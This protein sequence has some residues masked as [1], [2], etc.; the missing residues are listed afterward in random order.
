MSKDTIH[1]FNNLN[2]KG[3]IANGEIGTVGQILHSNGSVAYWALDDN[4]GG[5]ITSVATAN[6]LSGGPITTTGTIGVVTGS[7]L[8]VN[9]TGIHVNSALSITDLALTGNLTVSGT[10]TYINTTTLEVG[11]NIVT[12]NADLGANPPTENAG[13]EIMRGTSAN[14]QFI[15][16]ETNDRW[17]TNG[18]PISISSLVAAGAASGITTLAAGNTTITGFANVSTTLQV[19]TNTSTFGTAAYI[20]A[21]GNVG[22]GTS[23]PAYRLHVVAADGVTGSFFAGASYALRVQ[24]IAATG[25][26]VDAVNNTE[27]T[28]QPLLIGGSLTRFMVSG[29]EKMRLDASG[30]VGIGTSS[31]ST[32]LEVS[33][34]S[35]GATIEVLRLSNPGAGA[36]TAAQIKFTAA[37]TNYGTISGGYGA[38]VPQMTFNL[39][40][41]GNYVWQGTSAE[42]MRLDS[43]GNLGINVEPVAGYGKSIQL[44]QSFGAT[45]TFLFQAVDTDL[46]NLELL[47]NA[48]PP[49]G[50]YTAGYN[51]THTG[52]SA[53]KYASTGGNHIW[54]SASSGTAGSAIT[55]GERMRITLT[56]NVGIGN[57][58]PNSKLV[59]AGTVAMGNTTI[60]GFANVTST[61]QGGAGLTIA[62]AL[63]G[64]TTAA[65][66][67]TTI[68]GFANVTSTIQ[69]GA[70]LT[71]AGALAGVT[72]AAMGNTTITGFANV[73]TS[74]NSAML[75][76]GTSF[77][78][79][80]SQL[81]IS[82]GGS[83]VSLSN[84]TSNRITW[85]T[86]GVAAPTLTSYSAGTKLVLY[87]SVSAGSTGYAIGIDNST[88]WFSTNLITDA[89]GFK[90]YGGTTNYMSANATI[91]SHTGSI[92][93]PIFKD[94]DNTA[95]FFDGAST[96][97]INTLSGNGKTALETADG[98]LRI[99][100]SASFTNGIWTGSSNFLNSSG[101]FGWG[102]NGGTT[103]SRVYIN[104]GTYNGTNVI[105]LDGSNGRITA[106]DVRAPIFYDSDDTTYYI[107]PNGN[108]TRAAYLNGNLWIN[109]KSEPYGEGITFNMPTQATWG[110]LRWYR[111]GPGGS[112]AG[113][114]AF[115][116]FG[117]ESTN[118]IGFHNGTNGWRL[119][120]SFNNS[121]T[122]S[123]R[124]PIFYDSNNTA[125]YIDAAGTT[126][127]GDVQMGNVLNLNGWQESIAT[128]LFRGIEFHSVGDRSYY[129]GKP[130]GAWTQPLE[131]HFF[132]GIRYRAHLSYGGHQFYDI[133]DG[134]LKF[135]ISNGS[136]IVSSAVAFH[137]PI[138][139]DSNDTTYY[140]DAASTSNLNGLT[141]A[142]TITGSITGNA[143]TATSATSANYVG[144]TRD[145]PSSSLQYWQA[146]GLGSTEAPNGDWHNTIRMGHGSPL[147][148]YSSTL[149]IRMTGAGLG[150][151]YTQN[152]TAG[153]PQGWKKH[154]ND[155][156]D[157]SGSGLD[158][159]LLDGKHASDAVGVN[160]VVTR[161]ASNYTYLSYINSSTG[162]NENP[163]ISQIITTNNSDAFYRKS[164]LAH[165]AT[166]LGP[167][168]IT[169]TGTQYFQSNRDTT[170]NS[171]P[172]QAYSTSGGAIMSFHRAGIYAINMGLD[173]DNIF[174]IAG[175]SAAANAFQMDGSGNL[176]MLG[177]VTAYS[178]IRK[179][180]DIT[181]IE[182]ALDMVSRMRGVRFRRIDTDQVGVGVIA[183]E[184]LEVLPE[185][186]QQGIGNDDTMSVAYGNI[187]G[188]LIEAIKEQQAHI[189][190]LETKINSF[191]QRLI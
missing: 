185:V 102:S 191:E 163:T 70:G 189:N 135:S 151:I 25:T 22:I 72:T 23:S 136:N 51:Y 121:V 161:D 158:A 178:D 167:N 141:V 33:S 106:L 101:I 143:G 90:W 40:A 112:Y 84:G 172:L 50:G 75:T 7:T 155:G 10:R 78:A 182:N 127:L 71:I 27:A 177:N 64:V 94:S 61:I 134:A 55:F 16:D 85:G 38:T 53:T 120:H 144:T 190:K 66:G 188:V 79:N 35:A 87:D 166:S 128:T 100:Q 98:Y 109:P 126:R 80:S 147:S 59:V 165:L 176:T 58:A 131:I 8:T 186:V 6:G 63:A 92:H 108:G 82:S 76:V 9:T 159:D 104:G 175:W 118:D 24:S 111:N 95:F 30:N 52:S 116:Y 65:M 12:L 74:V 140:I 105:A 146:S 107:D 47:N 129:I 37:S 5:T 28:Y 62:G 149:A 4:S 83:A 152:I 157:G 36:D 150:D 31:P 145:T 138:F 88:M 114:W 11:D 14:A 26:V 15:W 103:S 169:W 119:D 20:V 148:Y 117:S 156:N 32:K 173:S 142:A 113:N 133:N 91:L 124:A 174:R 153:T 1:V 45:G 187:V 44:K 3:I 54:Y 57:T 130:A 170:S 2:V 154:W 180:K 168:G 179:K 171:P 183:Q 96:T 160:T 99:N 69:G 132:T 139:Y 60:T 18:Q 21:N 77:I 48:L 93:A 19:G 122:G 41:G 46:Q 29:L 181:T 125:Y 42:Q 110:G 17:S 184:M 81:T 67:N 164:S 115:G 89:G 73:S 43:S 68:T 49:A 97:N 86:G 56:G 34:T 13:I 123:F 39:P 137:A 162:T